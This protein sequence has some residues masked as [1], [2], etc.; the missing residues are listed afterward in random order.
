MKEDTN[1]RQNRACWMF[2]DRWLLLIIVLVGAAL[3]LL[4]LRSLQIGQPADDANYLILAE[5]LATGHGLRLICFPSA[6]LE[7]WFPAGWPLLLTPI[8]LI[9]PRNYGLTR[10]LPFAFTLV[11]I[12]AVYMIGRLY[13]RREIGLASTLLFAV[14]PAIVL[15]AGS[16][17]SEPAYMAFSLLAMVFIERLSVDQHPNLWTLFAA[18]LLIAATIAV[19]TIGFTLLAAAVIYLLLHHK[20]KIG[21]ALLLVTLAVLI[22]QFILNIS[23]GGA[24]LSP[25]YQVAV[26]SGLSE[27]LNHVLQNLIIYLTDIIPSLLVGAFGPQVD[28]LLQTYR[29]SWA[30]TAL[31]AAIIGTVGIGFAWSLHKL[32]LYHI[33]VALFFAATLLYYNPVSGSALPRYLAPILPFLIAFLLMGVTT[34]AGGVAR[35]HKPS[36]RAGQAALIA[37]TATVVLI[38]VGRDIQQGIVSPLR[39]RMTDVSA[40]ASWIGKQTSPTAIVVMANPVPRYIYAQRKVLWF[41]AVNTPEDLLDWFESEG[42]THILVGPPLRSNLDTTLDEYQLKYVVPLIRSYPERFRLEYT[43]DRWN[44][45]VYS[46][47]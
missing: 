21:L 9:S 40:G 34:L 6:P 31:K 10:I 7:Q 16:P 37:L 39:D 15:S 30:G 23:A 1:V 29:L 32:R 42:V 11:S 36:G 22:P 35:I 38:S 26:S 8:L 4:C 43:D 47:R 41:P 44:V 17:M 12:V 5:S 18:S 3:G 25:S 27:K 46:I 24:I 33:Y 13:W 28:R 45:K 2:R 14:A 19:R 20:T